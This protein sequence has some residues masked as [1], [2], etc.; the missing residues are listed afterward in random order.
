VDRWINGYIDEM[1][2]WKIDMKMKDEYEYQYEYKFEF[3]YKSEYE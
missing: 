1:D 2:R 3:A